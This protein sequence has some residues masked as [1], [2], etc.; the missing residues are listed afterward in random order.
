MLPAAFV[1]Y[2]VS[3]DVNAAA[4]AGRDLLS[5]ASLAQGIHI[6]IGGVN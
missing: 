1:C 3:R 5:G 4:V 6:D 2:G